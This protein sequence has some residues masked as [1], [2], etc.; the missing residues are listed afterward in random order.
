MIAHTLN[1]WATSLGL[2]PRTLERQILKAGFNP[3]KPRETI[4]AKKILS[5]VAGDANATKNRLLEAQAIAQEREN[6]NEDENWFH[7]DDLEK[8]LSEFVVIPLRQA[9]VS[10]SSTLDAK[11]NPQN[12]VVAREALVIWRD[13]TLKLCEAKLPKKKKGTQ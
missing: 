9:L 2:E 7:R 11:C 1:A 8:F 10:I 12:P 13:E 3:P 6:R 4:T 5:V